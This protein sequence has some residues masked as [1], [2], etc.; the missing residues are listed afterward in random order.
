MRFF[1]V[2][3]WLLAC[4]YTCGAQQK[5]AF[6]QEPDDRFKADILI[7]VAHPDDESYAAPY[8]ARAIH[9]QGKRVAVVLCTRGDGGANEAGSEHAAALG[10]V[11]E[12][13]A[14][15]G[16]A[17]AGIHN[18]WF[19]SGRDTA[20]QNV[21]QSLAHWNHGNVLEEVVRFIRLTRPEV[22]IAWLPGLFVGENHGDHQASGVIATEAFDMA[23]DPTAF[24][25]QVADPARRLEPFLEGLHAWQAKKIYYFSDAEDDAF[26]AGKGP[27]YSTTELSPSRHLPYWQIGLAQVR[28]YRSQFKSFADAVDRGNEQ[29]IAKIATQ[30]QDW[31][32]NPLPFIFGKSLVPSSAT[33]DIFEGITPAAIPYTRAMGYAPARQMGSQISLELAGPWGFY[34]D[35]RRAHGLASLPEAAVPEIGIEAGKPLQIPLHIS[36]SGTSSRQVMLSISLPADW[37][38]QNGSGKYTVAPSSIVPVQVNVATPVTTPLATPSKTASE[39]REIMCKMEVAGQPP[40]FVTLRVKLRPRALPQ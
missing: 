5:A 33:G 30:S 6:V 23:G 28:Y 20:S 35:F 37:V 8:L 2:I 17:E 29:E 15:R 31:W 25:A 16:L 14:R 22:V 38:E 3:V 36:N 39:F 19:A 21:L 34:R 27:A 40:A 1:A 32:S 4:S 7:V 12:I 18:V 24:P 11:R 13:E 10:L 9:D 26:F